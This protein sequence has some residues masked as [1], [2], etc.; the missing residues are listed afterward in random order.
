MTAYVVPLVAMVFNKRFIVCIVRHIL[1]M[2]GPN[3]G[4]LIAMFNSHVFRPLNDR[5]G[6]GDAE[7]KNQCLKSV[8]AGSVCLLSCK[9]CVCR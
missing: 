9:C 3:G 1:Q 6:N 7:D 2:V 5:N 4:K 8:N